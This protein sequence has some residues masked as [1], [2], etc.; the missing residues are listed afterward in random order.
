MKWVINLRK[1]SKER[2]RKNAKKLRLRHALLSGPSV[3]VYTYQAESWQWPDDDGTVATSVQGHNA[4]DVIIVQKPDFLSPRGLAAQMLSRY[5]DLKGLAWEIYTAYSVQ[6]IFHVFKSLFHLK[7][8]VFAFDVRSLRSMKYEMSS[9]LLD[10]QIPIRH[11]ADQKIYK[12]DIKEQH[13]AHARTIDDITDDHARRYVQSKYLEILPGIYCDVDEPE[14]VVI[15]ETVYPF[16]MA[17]GWSFKKVV[18]LL[19]KLTRKMGYRACLVA[20]EP[21]P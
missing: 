8:D 11:Y 12:A 5:Y 15:D 3:G 6:E 14:N 2:F 17:D 7:I 20:Q 21:T 18:K 4:V 19:Q 16:D 10:I 9:D 13:D 1:Q